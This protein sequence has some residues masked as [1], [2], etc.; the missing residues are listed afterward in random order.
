VSSVIAS[1]T[2]EEAPA[3]FSAWLKQRRRWFQGW[4]QTWLVHMRAPF[5]LLRDLGPAGFIT[6]QLVVGG[7]VLAALVHPL[8]LAAIVLEF[9]AIG[10]SPGEDLRGRLLSALYGGAFIG[11]YFTSVMLGLVGLAR[12]RLLSTAWVLLL[13]PIHWLL[14]SLAA[15]QAAFKL[16]RDP[17]RWDKTEHGLARTSRK[18]RLGARAGAK[19]GKGRIVSGDI[20]ISSGAIKAA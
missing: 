17:Y 19:P 18:A 16:V 8:F 11:G 15:W 5:R 4:M 9:T 1:T 7:T 14:L 20:R 13:V 12:R 10:S 6:L 2:Y 3:Q